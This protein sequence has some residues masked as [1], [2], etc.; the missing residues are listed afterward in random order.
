M[1]AK[2]TTTPEGLAILL[3]AEMVSELGIQANEPV[4]VTTAA[5]S[6][7]VSRVV[8]PERRARF[9]SALQETNERYAD[10]LRRLAE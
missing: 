3:S 8:G 4:E 7:I 6:L 2:V 5:Q 9:D 1:I 10:A